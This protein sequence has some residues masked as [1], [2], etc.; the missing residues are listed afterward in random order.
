MQNSKHTP[1]TFLYS[2]H[3]LLVLSLVKIQQRPYDQQQFEV[4]D[5]D[6]L[7]HQLC[8]VLTFDHNGA[9]KNGKLS[10]QYCRKTCTTY[11]D[12]KVKAQ[13]FT[14]YSVQQWVENCICKQLLLYTYLY[15][16]VVQWNFCFHWNTHQCFSTKQHTI[17]YQ[18]WF[19]DL[20]C[21]NIHIL[22]N[23]YMWQVSFNSY[24]K[25]NIN[26]K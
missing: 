14:L 15:N 2:A 8:W 22:L 9:N 17:M 5:G 19:E 11:K 6:P 12:Q 26:T 16:H 4:N 10:G 24:P 1:T 25:T 18:I 20:K 3:R 7:T 13:K 23:K 21:N